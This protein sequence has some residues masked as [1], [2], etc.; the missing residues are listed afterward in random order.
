MMRNS[1]NKKFLII[2]G[3][4]IF[5]IFTALQSLAIADSANLQVSVSAFPLEVNACESN[6]YIIEITNT[7]D[8]TADGIVANVTMPTG[9]S[10]DTG[11]TNIS[12]PNGSSTQNP[13][14]SGK[15]LEWNLSEIIG[16]GLNSSE[17]ITINFNLTAGCGTPSGQ[18]VHADVTY[19]GKSSY[20]ESSSIIVNEGY[21]KLTKTP[22]V[23]EAA[24]GDV[25]NWLI[26]IENTGTG[27]AYNV[28]INDS[29]ASGL[30]FVN[31]DSPSGELN[32]SYAKIDAGES[33]T[34]NLSVRAISCE[35]IYNE[36]NGSWRCNKGVIC[37][38]TY[39]KASVKL[40][41]KEPHLDYTISP[42][43]ITVPY[44]GASN[45]N[46]S[47]ANTGDGNASNLRVKVSEIP[48]QYD[49]TN[50]T[51]ATYYE[52]NSTFVVDTVEHDSSRHFTFDF[53]MNYGACD[54]SGGDISFEPSY[55]DDCG[56]SWAPPTKIVS[57]SIDPGTVSN[58]SVDK[59][60][61]NQLYLMENGT[62]TLEVRYHNGSCAERITTNIT[63]T[64]P[65]HFTVIDSGGGTVNTTARTI[66]W[67]NQ[68]LEN[69]T[70]WSTEIKLRASDDPCDCG[71]VFTNTLS[72]EMVTDCCGCSL[73]GSDS[74][75]IMV[76]CYNGTI[77]SSSN[78][79]ASPN[80]QECCR[81]ITYTNTY[82][83]N[84]IGSLNWSDI[85]FTEQGG[86]GQTFPDGTNSGSAT[87]KVNDTYTLTQRITIGT[88]INLGFL[89]SACGPLADGT[90]LDIDYTLHQKSVGTFVDWSD[91]NITGY[92]SEC[93]IDTNFHEGV[94]I[95]VGRS[96]FSI[97]MSYPNKMESCEVYEF[98]ISLS[99]NG[100][101][102]G[103]I[104]NITYN[105]ADFR[106][107][108]PAE[109]SNIT[110]ESGS[111]QSFEPTRSDHNLT[112]YLGKNVGRG[113]T[114]KFKVEKTCSQENKSLHA[115][116]EYKDN[117]GHPL[118]DSFTGEPLLLDKGDIIIKKTPEVIYAWTKNVSW[119]IY[120]TNK[121]D[122]TAYNVSV[123]DTLDTDL[124]YV[125]S[126]IDGSEDP[127]NTSVD[128][129]QTT[130]TLGNMTP[131]QQ[132]II[133]LNA[134]LVGCDNL[135]NYVVARW[136]CGGV[137]C[138][139]VSDTS[140]V[141]LPPTR[142]LI[143]RHDVGLVDECGDETT[144]E[145]EVRNVG[146]TNAY[147]IN[148]TELLP[149]GLR[150]VA[151]SSHVVG[152]NPS[153]TDFSG[154]PLI[155]NFEQWAPGTDV[156]I[157]FNATVTGPCDFNGGT[158]VARANYTVPCGKYGPESESSTRVDKASSH[159][160]ITKT[161]SFTITET[162]NIVRWT[163]TITSNG[164]Y[165]AK[166]ITL[167]DVLPSNTEYL[168]S[169]PEKDSGTGTSADPLIWKLTN[170]T[171]G[172]TKIIELNATVTNCTGYDTQNNAM[173]FWGCCPSALH[174]STAIAKL[175]T[176]PDI[177]LSKDHDYI[178]TCGGNY[179]I[180]IR[181]TGSTAYVTDVTD[182]LPEG[183]VYKSGSASIT[184]NNV[185]HTFSNHEP[186][187]FSSI[188]RT[189]IWTPD[190]INRIYPNEIITIKFGIVNCPNCCGSVTS[191]SNTVSFN[192]TDSCS[193][194]RQETFS[195]DITP[196]LAELH[197]RKEPETQPVGAASWTIYVSNT[198]TGTAYNVSV[199]DI[200]GNGFIN[201]AVT[202]GDGTITDNQPSSGWTTITWTGQ[203]IPVG[204]DVWMR[205]VTADAQATG[206]LT[207][208]VSVKGVCPTGCVYSSDSDQA[209][210]ARVNVTKEPDS[211]ET[212]GEY[213][214]FTITT[215][216]WGGGW[217]NDTKINDTLPVGLKYHSYKC[218]SGGCGSF[219]TSTSGGN[220]I[221][222]WDLGDVQG[223]KTV[224]I[225]LTTIVNDTISNQDGSTILNRVDVYHRNETG[226]LFQAY[227][228][229]KVDVVEP[230][231]QITKSANKS[232]VEYG[233]TVRYMINISHTRNSQHDAYDVNITDI[234]PEGLT[235]VGG[236]V[237]SCPLANST[238]IA[239][240][241][242]SWI[243]N[244]I[245]K[246]SSV[247]LS[248]EA[249][250]ESGVVMGQTMR[251]NATVTW[252]STAGDNPEERYGGWTPLD[253]YNKEKEVTLEVNNTA[254]ITKLPDETRS[255]T[256]G[257]SLNYTILV[258]LPKATARDLWVNDTLPKG[259]IY[260]RSSLVVTGASTSPS[261]TVSSPNDGTQVVYINWSFG[262]VNNSNDQDIKI[263]FNAI[264]ADVMDN[265]DG[266][267]LANNNAS[268]RWKDYNG[269]VHT[270]SDESGHVEIVE[271]DLIIEKSVNNTEVEVGNTIKYTIKVYHTAE[272][273]SDAF[274]L[275]INDTIPSGLTFVT[276]SQES[277][278]SAPSFTQND[279]KIS[280]TYD[281]LNTTYG[282][283]TPAILNYSVTVDSGVVS[284]QT[285]TNNA[286]VTWT[287]T[288]G[289][290]DNER[291]GEW[292]SL[293]NYNRTA[294]APVTIKKAS[295]ITKM[296]D[297][298]RSYT[299]GESLNYMID[300]NLPAAVVYN[301]TV[302]DTLPKGLIYNRS[303]LVVTGTSTSPSETVSS[304]ND[305]TQVVYI[306]WS[307]GKVNNSNDQDIKIEFNAIMADVIENQ[308]DTTLANNNASLRWKDYDGTVHTDSD[309][310]GPV[311]IVE[312]DLIIDKSAD[313]ATGDVGDTI[314]YDLV[315][316]HSSGS[317]ADAFDVNIT[318][319]I[320]SD[321]SYTPGSIEI[322]SGPDGTADDSNLSKL[323]WHFDRID[324]LW[325]STNK[326]LLRYNV[327]INS[328]VAPGSK[329]INNATLIWTSTSGYN[330]NERDGSGG[331]NNY[332]R[333]TS[334]TVK[335]YPI[336]VTKT[337]SPTSGAPC[338]NV[339]FTINITNTGDHTLN[340][341]KVVDTLPAGMSYVSS[342]PGADSHDGTITWNN[343][344]S[345]DSGDSKTIILVAHIDAN[346]V[347]ILTNYV[348]ATGNNASD[349][350]T[351][352][353]TALT[354]EINVEKNADPT[355]GAPC[356]NI[357]FTINI[358]NT[359]D[360]TLDPVKV[361][362]TLPAGMSYVSDD[363][364]GS[365]SAPN[366]RITWD[367]SSMD[368]GASATIHL[369]AHVDTGAT[370]TLTNSVKVTGKPP[371]GANVTASDTAN[372]TTLTPGI[373]VKKDAN[374]IAGPSGT[375][376][377]FT[378]TIT[379]TGDCT[380][381]PVKVADTLPGGLSYVSSSPKGSIAG[382]TITWANVGPLGSGNTT[383][384]K[385][386]AQIDEG[387]GG[388]LR[389]VATV[390]GTPLAGADVHDCD[391]AY[392]EVLA[393]T[394]EPPEKTIIDVTTEIKSDGI[395]IEGEQFGWETGN[396][397]LLNNPPL[398]PGEAVGGIKYDEKM[399]GSNGTTEFTKCFDV[400][401][402]VTPN[403]AVSKDIGY[404]S[405]DLGSLGHAEQVGMRYYGASPP[406]SSNTKCE[407]IEAGSAVVV[408]DIE[409]MTETWVGITETEER[410]LHYGINAEG[411]G[412]VSAGVD[413]S[414]EEG[415][416][417]KTPTSSMSHN[418]K[419]TA[420]SGNFSFHKEV[421]YTSKPSTSITTDLKG[422]STV[423]EEGQ[424]RG[425]SGSRSLQHDDK[426]I[427]SNGTMEFAKYVD[428]STSNIEETKGIGYK[429]GDLGSLSHSEQVGMRYS[430]TTKCEDVN[431]YGKMVVTN[432]TTETEAGITERSLH[433]GIDAEGNGFVSVGVDA[434]VEDGRNT[435]TTSSGMTYE[436]KSDAYG[437]F[438][439][440]KEIGYNKPP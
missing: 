429:S 207:N 395:V 259:L 66:T 287:S 20:G 388:M 392:I 369:V 151:G 29:L 402:N 126:K 258:D 30:E 220:T 203:T 426:M 285:L 49:I 328:G 293:D 365:V 424:F 70:T 361:V 192:Y 202:E 428:A 235:L 386:V 396:G 432:T 353:V 252:T 182:I 268:L 343:V 176:T 254:T 96:D 160:S 199:I 312:P 341:V 419:S 85:T 422:D 200:L 80:P 74:V 109:I 309:E 147:D 161:P 15:Y 118:S 84:H 146:E 358:N 162:N 398:A 72:T 112:W 225:N 171:V 253:N 414:V 114:I 62:Y 184:S 125:S 251:N 163:I 391:T 379:N 308:N 366:N 214:N 183:F 387:A 3:I 438:T 281:R 243:Y 27:P 389:N 179:T 219:S 31:V 36:V 155:W 348:N 69:G 13:V 86:N 44:C 105:D 181:N 48:S 373:N 174:T 100:P 25:I 430:S 401:T 411:K 216:F 159:L 60:G 246:G 368:P 123:V 437:N 223:P 37:Q 50:V 320:P 299:I 21:I 260:N 324:L 113:G 143:I 122:G 248:Y 141:E 244:Q 269:I 416:F 227:D 249:T 63:D 327:T 284:G 145:I 213:A 238:N 261:E 262:K 333:N 296:P 290:N 435:D 19:D 311:E 278:P 73:S 337:A 224:K 357:T 9:F 286:M 134:T 313:P 67:I 436:D 439:F 256:I 413:A 306:N 205:H 104:M 56:N 148:I 275:V 226:T 274:D 406:L 40:I 116:L 222:T 94:W 332:R 336:S 188:N 210:A 102:N 128:G 380:L 81:N 352:N 240:N 169:D 6:E 18:R 294:N 82:Q 421:D 403:L 304:P 10:Y 264:V 98:T 323:S 375:V 273:K 291:S 149:D 7:G 363:S 360:C 412:S 111:V 101:W 110:N 271:P 150:Y 257:E 318:D 5:T 57:Y 342:S 77:I 404:K 89:N 339:T 97:D 364:G 158:A 377:T 166:N 383:T 121:G 325:N 303:S 282:S 280:W 178:D 71:H 95:T 239:G 247:T 165:E 393:K 194:T 279:Q 16:G 28:I 47:F 167:K 367:F 189:I 228:T 346:A 170:M 195:Q 295:G 350:D 277:D 288:S 301:V 61:P 177:E 156:T 43:P 154:N 78:K 266:T 107:V 55:K 407:D 35:D 267:T 173:V 376:V 297:S 378:I 91:L 292:N 409:A 215:E 345:L 4:V 349:S 317:N 344:G 418:D 347:G 230:E 11:T 314:T 172:S 106:Y 232:F 23:V 326:V 186:L 185:S 38:E 423:I 196:K 270:D 206:D 90:K 168:S 129:K 382:N 302:N 103:Y 394:I 132:R 331:I 127:S 307:F 321:M 408:T 152:A 410:D 175:R 99:K 53:G 157:T 59:S 354:A 201:V 229:A 384:I 372:V 79:T 190:N 351:A 58:I 298:P 34:V 12:F 117:C 33:K 329:F 17:N 242:I 212:I 135:N 32:W 315:I 231:L 138:Q 381:D 52:S 405:G 319:I 204:T 310:S 68:Q 283:T 136:G 305:G 197:I 237:S 221:L 385:L 26:T 22:G 355:E 131:N 39:T 83:F 8:A 434:F 334:S 245:A 14:A 415:V 115:W 191:S 340:P 359:G 431:A 233:D 272:S 234:V 399:I 440:R 76:E 198:G 144:F 24:K 417:G 120:V 1:D 217:Y 250:V 211:I 153:S 374:P 41:L 330:P 2:L 45:V 142:L 356:A 139:E 236:S 289:P 64:Y 255:H 137:Y 390:T 42:D 335:R 420:Y 425:K 75:D 88:A 187:D 119:K 108:G 65:E 241:R 316:Y 54:A 370:G 263:E 371:Y 46:V 164:D 209:Y 276:G 180:T 124:S 92:P 133:D 87:F 140:R 400:N 51:G 208:T 338:T 397:N 362:D 93:S 130:W 193:G 427:G 218:V 433:Y 322:L 265:Q 300:I